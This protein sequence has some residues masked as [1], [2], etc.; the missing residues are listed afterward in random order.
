MDF[1][2]SLLPL[3]PSPFPTPHYPLRPYFPTLFSYCHSPIPHP[4]CPAVL[5]T[6]P[7]S[8]R[9]LTRRL[10]LRPYLVASFQGKFYI[11]HVHPFGARP[12]SS[13]AGQIGNATV[14]I[15]QAESRS[16]NR[17]FKYEDDIQ[18]FRYPNPLGRFS[19]GVFTYFHN[20]ETSLALIDIL[21]V[22]WHPEKSGI[23]FTSTTTFIGFQW[24]L[25]LHRVS[26]PKKKRVKYLTRITSILSDDFR[27]ERFTLRQIQQIHETLVHHSLSN[28]VLDTLYWWQ[29]RLEDQTAFRQLCPIGPVHD[30]KVFVDASTSWVSRPGRDICWL[31]TVAIELAILFM[32]QLDFY[33]QR[34]QVYSDNSGAIGAHIQNRS[35]NIAIN[36]SVRRS[37]SVLAEALIVPDFIYIDSASN[38]ADPISRGDPAPSSLT[39]FISQPPLPRKPRS[40]S[41]SLLLNPPDPAP[42]DSS[43]ASP[44]PSD[45]ILNPP[46]HSALDPFCPIQPSPDISENL[47]VIRSLAARALPSCSPRKPRA[48]DSWRPSPLQP[49]V[50]ADRRVLLW[51]TPHSEQAQ[52]SLDSAISPRLQ[53]KIFENLLLATS[54]STRQSYGAGLLRFTQFC[55]REEIPENLRMPASTILLSAFIADA[56]GKCTGNC[57]RNWLN[58]LRLWHLYNLADWHG[59]DRWVSSLQKSADIQHQEK[60]RCPCCA[61]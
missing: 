35:P 54:D 41:P 55:D 33:E 20:R 26:L 52:Q 16:E 11:D 30:Y 2:H 59:R 12:A 10:A 58:G 1:L 3:P 50:P 44:P 40:E 29:K 23:R 53:R 8:P 18:N 28:S 38:P 13:N 6:H 21:H 43:L 22:P 57:I 37:Y 24:D 15:W 36:L 31:E 61:K 27:G 4:T 60:S 47:H 46:S 48:A 17:L 56:I 34:V 42:P 25:T 5:L 14:D 9:S 19:D 49:I 45:L 39:V 7:S 32:R 51:T